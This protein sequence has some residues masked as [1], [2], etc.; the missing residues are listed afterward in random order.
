MFISQVEMIDVTQ[1]ESDAKQELKPEVDTLQPTAADD[2][3]DVTDD[4]VRWPPLL[5]HGFHS[6]RI[7]VLSH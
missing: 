7:T 1:D 4:V 2:E 6:Q 3:D 5:R